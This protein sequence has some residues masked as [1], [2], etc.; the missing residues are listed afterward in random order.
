MDERRAIKTLLTLEQGA[1]I[2]RRVR[3][4]RNA[5]WL[6]AAEAIQTLRQALSG[7]SIWRCSAAGRF[8]ATC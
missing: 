3:R 1:E 4:P 8:S 2:R 7:R 5:G 6:S